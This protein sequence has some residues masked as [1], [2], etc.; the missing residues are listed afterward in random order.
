MGLTSNEYHTG[1]IDNHY[2]IYLVGN[3]SDKQVTL[4]LVNQTNYIENYINTKEKGLQLCCG[5][6]YTVYIDLSNRLHYYGFNKSNF[7]NGLFPISNVQYV[8][9][10]DNHILYIDFSGKLWALGDNTHRQLLMNING[11]TFLETPMEITNILDSHSDSLYKD[12]VHIQCDKN[13]TSIFLDNHQVI[14]FGED[15]ANKTNSSDINVMH[16]VT[17]IN[18]SL[19]LHK[20][21][22]IHLNDTLVNIDISNTTLKSIASN[23]EHDHFVLCT[24]DD[25]L[26]SITYND[27]N[28]SID[29][30][31]L[32]FSSELKQDISFDGVV[33]PETIKEVY[34]SYAFESYLVQTEIPYSNVYKL[35]ISLNTT[36][37][38]YIDTSG[39]TDLYVG[40]DAGSGTGN[41]QRSSYP[42]YLSDDYFKRYNHN[43]ARD[44]IKNNNVEIVITD[45]TE[46]NISQ[47]DITQDI[48]SCGPPHRSGFIPYDIRT[49]IH[50]IID[51]PNPDAISKVFQTSYA[52]GILT[53]QGKLITWG[54]EYFGGGLDLQQNQIT[55][56]KTNDYLIAAYSKQNKKLYVRG[57]DTKYGKNYTNWISHT[58]ENILDYEVNK[59][60]VLYI[61]NN[62]GSIKNNIYILNYGVEIENGDEQ[63]TIQLGNIRKLMANG[64]SFYIYNDDRT[65]KAYYLDNTTL[66]Y[67]VIENDPTLENKNRID[68]STVTEFTEEEWIKT[69]MIFHLSISKF[70]DLDDLT[71]KYKTF[72][73]QVQYSKAFKIFNN[74]NPD[75]TS[76][77]VNIHNDIDRISR[78]YTISKIYTTR[79]CHIIVFIDS[80]SDLMCLYVFGLLYEKN[81]DEEIILHRNLNINNKHILSH[82]ID[83]VEEY[84]IDE[85]CFTFK[86]NDTL[87]FGGQYIP[88][89][90]TPIFQSTNKN[91]I[92]SLFIDLSSSTLDTSKT[93]INAK[94]TQDAVAI[95]NYYGEIQ[96]LGNHEYGGDMSRIEYL[97]N[98]NIQKHNL[99]STNGAFL[100]INQFQQAICW[101]HKDYGGYIS[102]TNSNSNTD[103]I[104]HHVERCH[105]N[106]Y[107]FICETT[108]GNLIAFGDSRYGGD[109][110]HL[111]NPTPILDHNFEKL[112]KPKNIYSSEKGYVLHTVNNTIHTWGYY[113]N[114]D[115]SSLN[116]YMSREKWKQ[117]ITASINNK[118]CNYL[119]FT[120]D[121]SNNVMYVLYEDSDV[122]YRLN[123][124]S[125]SLDVPFD[126]AKPTTDQYWKPM[127]LLDAVDNNLNSIDDDQVPF[128]TREAHLHYN[129]NIL[130]I[131][132]DDG[133]IQP[134]TG[135]ISYQYKQIN[136]DT[137]TQDSEGKPRYKIEDIDDVS[138]NH[139]TYSDK[140]LPLEYIQNQ[141]N[142]S[143]HQHFRFNSDLS[144]S[145]II[146]KNYFHYATID[147]NVFQPDELKHKIIH[148]NENN[149]QYILV[150]TNNIMCVGVCD[151]S[152]QLT[153]RLGYPYFAQ[154]IVKY[155]DISI[156]SSRNLYLAYVDQGLSDR[157]RFIKLPLYKQTLEYDLFYN[158]HLPK[159][160]YSLVEGI[161]IEMINNNETITN[162]REFNDIAIL[163]KNHLDLK[164]VLYNTNDELTLFNQYQD[165][166]QTEY[167]FAL[168]YTIDS[169]SDR[170]DVMFLS[171]DNNARDIIGIT[172]DVTNLATNGYDFI[173]KNGNNHIGT[174]RS[175]ITVSNNYNFKQVVSNDDAYSLL[176][177]N[178]TLIYI[179]DS[180]P[181]ENQNIKLDEG[182]NYV[183][184][185]MTNR[186]TIV[187]DDDGQLIALQNT[188]D[189]APYQHF[190]TN[191]N[192]NIMKIYG[193]QHNVVA[194]TYSFPY[195]KYNWSIEDINDISYADKITKDE[196]VYINGLSIISVHRTNIHRYRFN[197]LLSADLNNL[198]D[199]YNINDYSNT[200]RTET[201][202][203]K[204]LIKRN[205]FLFFL[206]NSEYSNFRVDR[207]LIE[208]I[209]EITPE[210]LEY[211]DNPSLISHLKTRLF[212]SD[213]KYIHVVKAS[214]KIGFRNV[215]TTDGNDAIFI[216][217]P[218]PNDG[219]RLD[220][221]YNR[222]LHF[223]KDYYED[224]Y[225]ILDYE[226]TYIHQDDDENIYS[227]NCYNAIQN[228]NHYYVLGYKL[229]FLKN[230]I[231]ANDIFN[232]LIHPYNNIMAWGTREYGGFIPKEKYIDFDTNVNSFFE[233][234]QAFGILNK[235]K[236]IHWGNQTH[237][238][239]PFINNISNIIPFT[240]GFYA[241]LNNGS[242]KYSGIDIN[243]IFY[244]ITTDIPQASNFSITSL[245]NVNQVFVTEKETFLLNNQH[246][247]YST[248]NI[249]SNYFS[250]GNT[251]VKNI[252]T[253]KN[254]FTLV[255]FNMNS[256]SFH[257]DYST[258]SGQLIPSVI[259]VSN[260]VLENVV[261]GQYVCQD[262]RI[263]YLSNKQI[264]TDLSY[265]NNQYI[266][267]SNVRTDVNNN[268]KVYPVKKI[269][270]NKYGAII[271]CIDGSVR[272]IRNSD[273]IDTN[274]E[275][276]E[277]VQY[278][279]E[280]LTTSSIKELNEISIEAFEGYTQDFNTD[281][282]IIDVIANHSSFLCLDNNGTIYTFG[283]PYTGG[284][285]KQYILNDYAYNGEDISSGNIDN[286]NEI[287]RYIDINTE[288]NTFFKSIHA[289]KYSF[290]VRDNNDVIYSFGISNFGGKFR[291]YSDDKSF[292]EQ[293]T[294]NT[295]DISN[296]CQIYET[297]KAYACICYKTDENNI[298]RDFHIKTFGH[299]DFGG[300]LNPYLES[301]NN[302]ITNVY[303]TNNA[304]ISQRVYY[305]DT[306]G[307]AWY[308]PPIEISSDGE[309]INIHLQERNDLRPNNNSSPQVTLGYSSISVS[310][311]LERLDTTLHNL[312]TVRSDIFER[313]FRINANIQYFDISYS[314]LLIDDINSLG[315]YY[316][317][318]IV[319]VVRPDLDIPVN[320]YDIPNSRS[321]FVPLNKPNHQV[322]IQYVY[323]EVNKENGYT[324][325]IRHE[326][327]VERNFDNRY[328]C[329]KHNFTQLNTSENTGLHTLDIKDI[330]TP[331]IIDNKDNFIIDRRDFSVSIRFR[332]GILS[333]DIFEPIDPNNQIESWGSKTR[334]GT[335]FPASIY[336]DLR[337]NIQ[338]VYSTNNMF[339][340]INQF[341]KLSVWGQHNIEDPKIFGGMNYDEYQK[342]AENISYVYSNNSA[343]VILYKDGTFVCIGEPSFG[344]SIE[345]TIIENSIEK[346]IYR[347]RESWR[348]LDIS[349]STPI[350]KIVSTNSAFL[351]LDQYGEMYAWGN[352]YY[353][354]VIPRYVYLG[355]KNLNTEPP[356]KIYNIIDILSTENTFSAI[357][358]PNSPGSGLYSGYYHTNID[359]LSWPSGF[360]TDVVTSEEEKFLLFTK[361]Q[362]S[363]KVIFPPL[364][365]QDG[366]TKTYYNLSDF[367]EST[368]FYFDLQIYTF[369]KTL[370]INLEFIREEYLRT[371]LLYTTLYQYFEGDG[372]PYN[373]R[374]K[375]DG[376]ELIPSVDNP[377]RERNI[378]YIDVLTSTLGSELQSYIYTPFTRIY[379]HNTYLKLSNLTSQYTYLCNNYFKGQYIKV[380]ISE[381]D[382]IKIIREDDQT[383]II[384]NSVSKRRIP[385][386]TIYHYKTFDIVF[387]N[388]VIIRKIKNNTLVYNSRVKI[389]QISH[390]LSNIMFGFSDAS[391]NHYYVHRNNATDTS[392]TYPTKITKYTKDKTMLWSKIYKIPYYK[393]HTDYDYNISAD[394]ANDKKSGDW[395]AY[396]NTTKTT[397]L[398]LDISDIIH[399]P[400]NGEFNLISLYHKIQN[401]P[402]TEFKNE[403][404]SRSFITTTQLIQLFY[405]RDN[406][407]S[408]TLHK[409]NTST[410]LGNATMNNKVRIYKD[411]TFVERNNLLR[412]SESYN[413]K[414]VLKTPDSFNMEGY[415]YYEEYDILYPFVNNG[416]DVTS[417]MVVF[418][419]DETL[420][421][422]VQLLKVAYDSALH[423]YTFSEGDTSITNSNFPTFI[424]DVSGLQEQFVDVSYAFTDIDP[425][426]LSDAE[427]SY[428]FRC[429]HPSDFSGIPHILLHSTKESTPPFIERNDENTADEIIVDARDTDEVGIKFT[430]NARAV[431][432]T[433]GRVTVTGDP[434][435]GGVVQPEYK[436]RFLRSGVTNIF[437]NY[438]A[439][440][441]IKINYDFGGISYNLLL[442]GV[443]PTVQTT[444]DI[445]NILFQENNTVNKGFVN[446]QELLQI[447]YQGN[448]NIS[449]IPYDHIQR[450]ISGDIIRTD[451]INRFF[452]VNPL[453]A[454]KSIKF[455]T[456][457]LFF[458]IK[459]KTGYFTS[460]TYTRQDL[461]NTRP[462]TKVIKKG[463]IL[464]NDLNEYVNVVILEKP[465][466]SVTVGTNENFLRII[467]TVNGQYRVYNRYYSTVYNELDFVRTSD[468]NEFLTE[469]WGNEINYGVFY[470]T[471]IY[472]GH[473]ILIYKP[474]QTAIY[475]IY[476]K[477]ITIGNSE[478]GGKISNIR[479]NELIK[480]FFFIY[481]NDKA[482]CAITDDADKLVFSW[483]YFRYGG[484]YKVSWSN[485]DEG[486]IDYIAYP[487]K[488][489]QSIER[490]YSTSSA[491]VSIDTSG[492]LFTW[493]NLYGGGLLPDNLK[494]ITHNVK[495]Y[496]NDVAFV[497]I[498]ESYNIH[499][500]GDPSFVEQ[501]P[502]PDDL[503]ELNTKSINDKQYMVKHICVTERAFAALMTNS[504]VYT[505]GDPSYG[506]ILPSEFESL[507]VNNIYSTNDTFALITTN[508]NVK[509]WGNTEKFTLDTTDIEYYLTNTSSLH[510]NK[511]SYLVRRINNSLFTFG[512]LENG[513]VLP[514]EALLE[515]SSDTKYIISND[516]GFTTINSKNYVIS[517]GDLNGVDNS[518]TTNI[519]EVFR[520][521]SQQGVDVYVGRKEYES[522]YKT[523][524]SFAGTYIQNERCYMEI[525]GY[526]DI[527]D[528][529][530]DYYKEA[531]TEKLITNDRTIIIKFV[532]YKTVANV[533]GNDECYLVLFTDGSTVPIG[534]INYGG[535][536][537]PNSYNYMVNVS[538][539]YANPHSF[540]SNRY[541][542]ENIYNESAKKTISYWQLPYSLKKNDT[543]NNTN[544]V[545]ILNTNDIKFKE[546]IGY[547]QENSITDRQIEIDVNTFLKGILLQNGNIDIERKIDY[548]TKIIY[549][550]FVNNPLIDEFR[551]K[552]SVFR[553]TNNV[554]EGV[555]DLFIRRSNIDV[556]LNIYP[557]NCNIYIPLTQVGDFVDIILRQDIEVKN[558]ISDESL[559]I[560]G[561]KINITRL[562]CGRYRTT[563]QRP[564]S[565]MKYE[566][567]TEFTSENSN[568]RN[569]QYI[570]KD[571]DNPSL[572]NHRLYFYGGVV[573]QDVK[574]VIPDYV[575]KNQTFNIN[576]KNKILT[577]LM[578]F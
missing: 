435:Y 144:N 372:Y 17:S 570:W 545:E 332:D 62:S 219:V 375:D 171:S 418:I 325:N 154:D 408:V 127:L 33:V 226:E 204:R 136:L 395:F 548:T 109:I 264:Y 551:T 391:F 108:E 22:S 352:E 409:N 564:I 167:A 104:I 562:V 351:A 323:N 498:D 53:K 257:I 470:G 162:V 103:N 96:V 177:D 524:R 156:D 479:Y 328:L 276:V 55:H 526:I 273:E 327:I 536:Y 114:L 473:S 573:I 39:D 543:K 368:F 378:T 329:Y 477:L 355:Y 386:N 335:I 557:E 106:N 251:R 412:I 535:I 28:K 217:L 510:S 480:N 211:S 311:L 101:G 540:V 495:I 428:I 100:I 61:S 486:D 331:V 434:E 249:Q 83:N 199:D 255:D 539:I 132:Y 151:I 569:K 44:V 489:I 9:C 334:G 3:N 330:I 76:D 396:L 319:R 469:L 550:L 337:N 37:L 514:Y 566:N 87:F 347:P 373:K 482:L 49:T 313:L 133:S 212:E 538:S 189:L 130:Y 299:V 232:E 403:F 389:D 56:V 393:K 235:G 503:I 165:Q 348:D 364:K 362:A 411:I 150:V 458:E 247:C 340:A 485:D 194:S 263:F 195:G 112:F 554:L 502:L 288:Y 440:T 289:N 98:G 326:L 169:G 303:S 139:N 472:F 187:L 38:T 175:Y 213:K 417:I 209:I 361:L 565:N 166:F 93:I 268:I 511:D 553:M 366:N 300:R 369:Y 183:N 242:L 312:E 307:Y 57:L 385:N 270:D 381:F 149:M 534:N 134:G 318:P 129:H 234:G 499:Y 558:P 574:P 99:Y 43:V 94:T 462:V 252:I 363:I 52:S 506:G 245:S 474:R 19:F 275:F 285:A 572:Y 561:M 530:L 297:D 23:Y 294:D 227:W 81:N 490:I 441:A 298:R 354:G 79:T 528:T 160:I 161:K 293:F 26:Y 157:A 80:T 142:S 426:N 172:N 442:Q 291:Y 78:K 140:I 431:L 41:Q 280:N 74:E 519:R 201:R 196:T 116:H 424:A 316:D 324:D 358:Q 271:L 192:H 520:C 15:I 546:F 384:D 444:F 265:N 336:N 119:S 208:D 292:D 287:N 231:I 449:K 66:L 405:D 339:M 322:N 404:D 567:L 443:N 147:G 513:G 459:N 415:Y 148:D 210:L 491:F 90:F 295:L 65:Q 343:F 492:Q 523:R 202:N 505:W 277:K 35:D 46:Y 253:S 274:V 174:I 58:G 283:L 568:N 388:T 29:I 182:E 92:S 456:S 230:F 394:I 531:I 259:E 445:S 446:L 197:E 236:F 71:I 494:N 401:Y 309:M 576:Y 272:F 447:I 360:L 68:A 181:L 544:S 521:V 143:L 97:L 390:N 12:I 349:S 82:Q 399:P 72:L 345:E 278:V 153:Y 228:I 24:D 224:K 176:T 452:D 377:L 305:T 344:G 223:R 146:Y 476:T 21:N 448:E 356:R 185:E 120:I 239:Q 261:Y 215:D 422:T 168:E 374:S 410:L 512:K 421:N 229:Y 380:Y 290:V 193:N 18:S 91:Y 484:R 420:S 577:K 5:F 225:N 34:Y 54:M 414:I 85:Y 258:Q 475:D 190:I 515:L 51:Y 67:K 152:N 32:S 527:S 357:I 376:I 16:H 36:T 556:N 321:L 310:T 413:D 563:Y 107:S 471:H 186:S 367:R 493:G 518:D 73:N 84:T 13:N 296:V 163:H 222:V 342:Y 353:G 457:S 11:N 27:T 141:Q 387:F 113:E 126:I 158:H 124:Y 317:K 308:L 302:Y 59:Q 179:N 533:V 20:D 203:I 191:I 371:A 483:G 286:I 463:H 301:N 432:T 77:I 250:G 439:F 237:L 496:S 419:I 423:R 241:I 464:E 64:D 436:K 75:Y 454:S 244:L 350:V 529:H 178:N 63:P 537:N 468:R 433:D 541:L 30:S 14:H 466:D 451:V 254:D 95:L 131:K 430:L 118:T 128:S 4:N 243:Q 238:A 467:R 221:S 525:W 138:Y 170:T 269:V 397:V 25:K 555:F 450:D 145:V 105:N 500:W 1:Y 173:M 102:S 155:A 111:K 47:G 497:S 437:A 125:L 256:Y 70:D 40:I 198:V 7:E 6:K 481:N 461:I 438:Y 478:L 575:I 60:T 333:H 284:D 69:N 248:V 429:F 517:W 137:I 320:V 218:H 542:Y 42:L 370:K 10:G 341:G 200:T 266:D 86:K 402:F 135:S 184:F 532:K 359:T 315:F 453:L 205:Y 122:N 346:T 279:R 123:I 487:E 504:K 406:L 214:H 246:H 392:S 383:F 188:N 45:G 314:E 338:K 416:I 88:S 549:T 2:D 110:S 89:L 488:A 117:N 465:Y 220:F 547:T 159:Q 365:A 267:I 400:T 560:I 180:T 50:S 233:N 207:E 571:G 8:A 282:K 578:P 427:Q 552:P 31:M 260:T 379:K 425:M 48:Y 455:K 460:H 306:D 240:N 121:N 507:D 398:L 304:F 501:Y 206:H 509:I 382:Y 559:S 262:K 281:I 115:D 508:L 522:I 164:N 216:Y 516:K 407:E